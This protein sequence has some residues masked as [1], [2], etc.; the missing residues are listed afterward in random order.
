VEV[1]LPQL[2][3]RYERLRKRQ[4]RAERALLASL[5]EIGQQTPPIVVVSHRRL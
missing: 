4:P 5:A 1:E 2:T 3:L